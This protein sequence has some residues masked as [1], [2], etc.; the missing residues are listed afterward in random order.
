MK[1]LL[2]LLL[3]LHVTFPS[4]AQPVTC[5]FKQPLITIHFGA[6][7]VRDLNLLEPNSY[8][9]VASSCP[10]DGHYTYTSFTSDC[11]GGDWVTL[12]EDHTPG[13]AAGNMMLVNA[14]PRSSMFLT[15]SINGLKGGAIYEFAVW[16]L[17]VCRPTEKCP[18]PLLPDIV[19]MLQTPDGKVVS[20]FST[21]EL[22]RRDAPQWT[23]YQVL[24]TAP[25][26]EMPL[27]L[28][29]ID[30]APGGCG[31]DFALDDI[32][33]RECIPVKPV[34]SAKPKSP[35]TTKPKPAPKT[36]V[37]VN[38]KSV[39]PK[40]PDTTKLNPVTPKNTEIVKQK[41]ATPKPL[42][43]KQ[44]PQ[45]VKKP[46]QTSEITKPQ[47]DSP[48]HTAPVIKPKPV[49]FPAPPAALLT[50]PNLLIKEI[51]TDAPEVRLDL[52]DNGEIDGDTVSVYHN[53]VLLFSHARLSE[54][55]ISFNITMDAEH[56]HHELVMV[57]E[58]LGSIPP[59]T[60][61]MVVKA[62]TKRYEVFISSSEQKNAKVI[63]DLKE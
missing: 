53:N 23:R 15:T 28:T 32:T 9:R 25:R 39:I 58:N 6:G 61:L 44:T 31:N 3:I 43:K 2:F 21:G 57:A 11:F 19:I 50:R 54:K 33:F 55:A 30:N 12:P 56:P 26:S 13:D 47:A 17:N 59:N 40:K 5:T 24:F 7:N 41:P 37:I 62:G 16:M 38:Q 18:Y 34:I 27:T 29:M 14:S 46:L 63:I 52:Y 4:K 10:T 45:P 60:S 49:M 20:Q 1:T 51:E 48:T 35:V 42:P 22:V 36:P 8:R